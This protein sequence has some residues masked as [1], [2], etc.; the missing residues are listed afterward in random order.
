[1]TVTAPPPEA[2]DA[3][4]ELMQLREATAAIHDHQDQ[5]EGLSKQRMRLVLA[6]RRRQPPVLFSAIA[7]AADTTEQTIYKIHREA[8][9]AEEAGEL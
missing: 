9:R 3:D 6:L 4:E 8:R 7:E 2:T 1:V 5:V